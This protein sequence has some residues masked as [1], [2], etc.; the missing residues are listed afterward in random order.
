MLPDSSTT[1]ARHNDLTRCV[2]WHTI[3]LIIFDD[4]HFVNE[5]PSWLSF[6]RRY[7]IT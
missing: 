3:L 2:L 4:K 6:P 7:H 1:I 5:F